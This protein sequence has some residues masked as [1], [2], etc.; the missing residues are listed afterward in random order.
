MDRTNLYRYMQSIDFIYDYRISYYGHTKQ[1]PDIVTIRANYL[2]CVLKYRDEGSNTYYQDKTWVFKNMTISKLWKFANKKTTGDLITPQS[3]RVERSILSHVASVQTGLLD[4]SML[5][6]RGSKSKKSADFHSEM[7][8][9]VFSDWYNSVVFPAIAARRENA[10]LVLDRATYHTYIDE[11]DKRP[12][13]SWIKTL[14]IDSIV[15]WGGRSEDWPLT[16][17]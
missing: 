6:Y 17:R 14:V 7:N 5:L 12:N 2:K 13:T 1:R 8:W 4:G 11:E 3:G 16:W 9:N 10:V 15:R